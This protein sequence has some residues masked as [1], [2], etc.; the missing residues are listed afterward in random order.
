M[1]MDD[2]RMS[3]ALDRHITGN[4]GED[5][6]NGVCDGCGRYTHVESEDGKKW[7]CDKCFDRI[8]AGVELDIEDEIEVFEKEPLMGQ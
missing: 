8:E 5:Q 7:F 4:Y 3:E 2:R 1:F 6:L